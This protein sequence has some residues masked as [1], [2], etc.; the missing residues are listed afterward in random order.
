M[1]ES[2]ERQTNHQSKKKKADDPLPPDI[3]LKPVQLQRRRVWRACESCR[4]KKIKCDGVE[5]TCSQCSTSRAQCTWLQ[6]KDRAALSRHYVQELEARLLHMETLFQQVAPILEQ[7]GQSGALDL[8]KLALPTGD[9]ST[10]AMPTLSMFPDTKEPEEPDGRKSTPPTPV[11]IE[12]DMSESFGQLALDEHGQM[13]WIG[14]S[15]TMSLIHSFRTLTSAP[16]HR[17]SPMEDDPLGPGPSVNKLYFPASVFFGKVRVLPGPEEVEFPPRDLADKLVEAYFSRFHFLAP[18]VD[19]PTFLSRYNHL[20][21]NLGDAALARR[22]T[23]FIALS[24]AV[25]A[26]AAKLVEDPRLSVDGLDDAGI[27]MV[28]YERALILQYISHA[29]MQ[30]EHVQCFLLMSTFLCSVNCLPQAWIMVGQAVRISQDIGLHRSPRRLLIP[31]IEKETRRKVW[32]GC[33]ILDRMLA[34]TLG[35]PLGIDDRDCDVELPVDVDDDYLSDYFAG[36]TMS[37]KAPF[38]MRGFLE[39]IA[40]YGIAGK[41]L[42]Q[43]YSLDKCKEYLEPEKRAELNRSVETL[44]KALAQWCDDLPPVLKTSPAHEKHV[45][46]AAVLCTHYYSILLTLHRNFLPVKPD[47]PILPRSTARAVSTARACIH[48]APSIRNVVPPCYHL[49]F[50]IQNLFSSAVI[51]LLYSMHTTD[52]GASQMAMDEAN[53]CLGILEAW[54]GYWPG[55]RKCKELLDDLA[56]TANEAIK[57]LQNPQ[58]QQT[59]VPTP[60][61]MSS[62]NTPSKILSG[63]ASPSNMQDTRMAAPSTLPSSDRMMKNKAR[64][65]RSRDVRLSPRLVP[66]SGYHPLSQRA[67]S[68]SR[69]RPHDEDSFQDFGNPSLSSVLSG[70][71]AGRSN[72]SSHSSPASNH[73][74]S[75]PPSRLE[76]P[77]EASPPIMP[78]GSFSMSVPPQ[79]PSTMQLPSSSRFSYDFGVSRSPPENRWAGPS[80]SNGSKFYD[81][82]SGGYHSAYGLQPTASVDSSNSYGMSY[83]T[84]DL[85][86]G[87][88]TLSTVPELT[89][90]SGPGLPFRGLDYIRNFNGGAFTPGSEHGGLWQTFDPGAF[91]LDPEVAFSLNDLP[92]NGQDAQLDWTSEGRQ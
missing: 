77:L 13:R 92:G 69:K 9:G 7:V 36:A 37:Q 5:P 25:F 17:V 50:F 79:S 68:T 4:R 91:G 52:V 2:P 61:S 21:D 11:K 83:D 64:R 90:F 45:S 28:Y 27:G 43:V 67:R 46:M 22:E 51:I 87:L 49:A 80:E 8:S 35:R 44:D 38:L 57:A 48:L 85:V 76:P 10:S 58:P 84:N 34:L 39:L 16:L 70:S 41:V 71:Y 74:H 40:L 59:M 47:Q 23:A 6:T 56:A 15:S 12:D 75:S 29:S 33:Y 53:S 54:E 78:I 26:C 81:H 19:K 60:S 20:M 1:A 89:D 55:A 88:S 32:W 62:S 14:S 66:Q 18:I 73:S 24:N 82:S 31:P 42:R 65:N 63:T 72:L 86:S 30:V 3:G